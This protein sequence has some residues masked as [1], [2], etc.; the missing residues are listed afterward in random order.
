MPATRRAFEA[1][2]IS[3]SAVRL[4]SGARDID[5]D[6]FART[7]THLV[8]A[9][10]LHPIA[11]LQRVVAFWRDRAEREREPERQERLHAHRTLHASVT[12]GGM[13]RVDGDLDPENGETLLTALR[14]VL[15]TDARSRDREDA[16]SPAQRRA[17]ALGEICR[18]WLDD[19]GR[20]IVAGERPHMTVTVDVDA[21]EGTRAG[22]ISLDHTGAAGRDMARR[23]ACDASV[24]RVVMKG[25]SEPLDVGR[26]TPVVPPAVRRAVIVRDGSCRFPGCD[27][28]HT[29]C[30]AHHVEHWADGGHHEPVE[31]VAPLSAP[32]PDGARVRRVRVADRVGR[33]RV[34]P[35]GRFGVGGSSAPVRHAR[36]S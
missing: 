14:A 19:G 20:P 9:A 36:E 33:P 17:D 32:S 7:E 34:P 35:P 16:R 29:W 13:V 25:R 5:P 26:R 10:R 23:L 3:M 18:Q 24:M 22:T 27:R 21:L 8:N 12:L 11:E 15:D 6:T 31:P 28:P 2:E 1:N 4:L 30:D